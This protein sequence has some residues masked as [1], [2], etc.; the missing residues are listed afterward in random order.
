[1]IEAVSRLSIDRA[2]TNRSDCSEA[3]VQLIASH[4]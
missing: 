3:P 2:R 1:M 4:Q